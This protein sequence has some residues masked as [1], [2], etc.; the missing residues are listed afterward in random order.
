MRS[1]KYNYSN[2]ARIPIAV[3]RCAVSGWLVAAVL[4]S[5]TLLAPTRVSA[6]QTASEYYRLGPGDRI[7]VTVAGSP[8]FSTTARIRED[9][10]IGYPYLGTVQV[11]GL[12]LEQAENR[13]RRELLAAKLL[14]NP[15]VT[16]AVEQFLS[17]QVTVLGEVKNPKRYGLSAP[18]TVLDMIAEAGGRLPD[19]ADYVILIRHENGQSKRYVLTMNQLI[20]GAAPIEVQ[21]NDIIVV[22]RMNVFY[23][24]GAVQK[25]G[26]YR[27][28]KGMTV[29]QAIAVG[30]G[31]SP[32]GSYSRIE[33]IR[34]DKDGHVQTLDAQLDDILQPGDLL[35]VKERIF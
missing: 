2:Y 19:G 16:V 12:T 1:D 21:A 32:R 5:L 15:Q 14:R 30:G 10:A 18:S 8:E 20:A 22:P 28:D 17:R 34:H 31:L 3:G 11:G 29:M 7:S 35:H 27:L 13:I 9:G 23:I 4:F 6:Q 24:E 25:A 26:E 33:I